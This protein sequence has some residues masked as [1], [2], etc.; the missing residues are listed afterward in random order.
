[1]H[2]NETVESIG[3]LCEKHAILE[4]YENCLRR[5]ES[6]KHILVFLSISSGVSGEQSILYTSIWGWEIQSN[7]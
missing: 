5:E 1:M 7:E 3:H 2:G 4:L 6:Y